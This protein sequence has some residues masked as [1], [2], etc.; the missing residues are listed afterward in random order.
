MKL[1]PWESILGPA[2]PET[3]Q[4]GQEIIAAARAATTERLRDRPDLA[5]C[6]T[7]AAR[8]RHRRRGDPWCPECHGGQP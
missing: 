7:R 2:S 4:A 5:P 8:R 1:G 3:I 6:D